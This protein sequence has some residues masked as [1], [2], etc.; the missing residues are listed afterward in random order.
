MQSIVYVLY[1]RS[2][3]QDKENW[4]KVLWDDDKARSYRR[5]ESLK[6]FAVYQEFKIEEEEQNLKES[7]DVRLKSRTD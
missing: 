5:F 4:Y 3:C 6:K 1:T 7:G 2:K